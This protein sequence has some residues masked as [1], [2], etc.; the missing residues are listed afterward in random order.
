MTLDRAPMVF[1]KAAEARSHDGLL[2]SNG[3][4]LV[5]FIRLS[6]VVLV[7]FICLSIVVAVRWLCFS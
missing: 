5:I 4:S 6:I 1:E 2:R 3:S 7:I